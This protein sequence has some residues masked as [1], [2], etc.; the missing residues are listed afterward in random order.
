ME[1]KKKD[2]ITHRPDQ[3]M[4]NQQEVEVTQV[5]SSLP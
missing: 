2:N 1:E 3:T 4:E 5:V